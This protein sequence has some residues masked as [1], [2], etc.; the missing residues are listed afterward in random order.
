MFLSIITAVLGTTYDIVVH[1]KRLKIVE[2]SEHKLDKKKAT[3]GQLNFFLCK[4]IFL[5]KKKQ[6]LFEFLFYFS[7]I[8]GISLMETGNNDPINF[9]KKKENTFWKILLCFSIYTNTKSLFHTNS[10]PDSIQSIHGLRF[11][12]MIWIILI[13]VIYFTRDFSGK[14]N[15][16]IVFND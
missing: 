4:I 14:K 8:D 12:S 9:Y 6:S 2:L 16:L 13:H 3:N 5:E 11:I 7:G 1:Q 15:K 10:G